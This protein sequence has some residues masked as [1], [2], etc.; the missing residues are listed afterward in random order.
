MGDDSFYNNQTESIHFRFKNIICEHKMSV[1]IS[2]KPSKKCTLT[3]AI[4]IYKEMLQ[5]YTQNAERALF[6]LVLTNVHQI[7]QGFPLHPVIG[8]RCGLVKEKSMSIHSVRQVFWKK[9][10]I[11]NCNKTSGKSHHLQVN[12]LK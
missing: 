11:G 2:G 4:T 9:P 5:M 3:E 7:M 1:E 10:P 6:G 12:L 8:L